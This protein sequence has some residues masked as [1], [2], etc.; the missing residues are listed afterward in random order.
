MDVVNQ[1]ERQKYFVVEDL[2]FEDILDFAFIEAFV[3]K[4]NEI[5][6]NLYSTEVLKNI[7]TFR[8]SNFDVM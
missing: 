7:S 3:R 4:G 8:F 5:C 1:V 6:H 2:S